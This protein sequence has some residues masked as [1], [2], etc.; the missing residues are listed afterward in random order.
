MNFD[1]FANYQVETPITNYLPYKVKFP[2]HIALEMK[3]IKWQDC[4]AELFLKIMERKSLQLF[5]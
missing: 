1:S 3:F 5:P 4:S 2:I